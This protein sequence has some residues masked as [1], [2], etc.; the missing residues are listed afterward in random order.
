MTKR[1]LKREILE[2][3]VDSLA[4]GD[5]GGGIVYRSDTTARDTLNSLKF[6]S[7]V[8]LVAWW[9]TRS[10]RAFRGQ[11]QFNEALLS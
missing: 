4:N 7:S 10:P 11:G 3:S 8:P 1:F 9:L 2:N 6:V 5:R